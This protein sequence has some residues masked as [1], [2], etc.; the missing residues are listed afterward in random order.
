M[1]LISGTNTAV[2][3]LPLA[4]IM[5][6][7]IQN[8]PTVINI[9][10][11]TGARRADCLG[12]YLH[13]GLKGNFELV[14]DVAAKTTYFTDDKH[15]MRLLD[16]GDKAK[17]EPVV[18]APAPV[19]E[20]Q[21][22][23]PQTPVVQ[24]VPLKPYTPPTRGGSVTLDLIDEEEE[25]TLFAIPYIANNIN[26]H[27]VANEKKDSTIKQL[28]TSVRAL[29]AEKDDIYHSLENQL[30]EM[31][32]TYEKKVAEANN[33][34]QTLERKVEEVDIPQEQ[35]NF[36]KFANYSEHFKG[37]QSEGWTTE[38]LKRIGK[39][40]SEI[41]VFASGGGSSYLLMADHV[42]T[43][44]QDNPTAVIVDFSNDSY[45]KS[46]Y[47]LKT[48]DSSM[49]LNKEGVSVE[50]VVKQLNKVSFVPTTN[51]NDI[52]LLAIE[53]DKVMQK[54]LSYANGRPIIFLFGNINNFSVRYSVSKLAQIG[55][56]FLFVESNPIVISTLYLD[57]AF[58]PEIQSTIV[59]LKF[60][61]EVEPLVHKL[62]EKHQVFAISN[63]VNWKKMGVTV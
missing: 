47:K 24:A 51:Y 56:L 13:E 55:R 35:R 20:V 50:R 2:D 34:I 52:G 6:Y 16:N 15:L 38:E 62:G 9:K 30:M 7:E 53:W 18:E 5:T 49:V 45:F 12:V 43:L 59:C 42:H 25:E 1:I 11:K 29:E 57:L 60:I 26:S 19:E 10:L 36:L 8:D 27:D 44:M 32:N 41:Y 61:K 28:E 63:K 39:P 22:I 14:P 54:L 40:K 37:T 17:P 58:I 3:K 31:R 21:V 46:K 23:Q 4:N 33:H 48:K